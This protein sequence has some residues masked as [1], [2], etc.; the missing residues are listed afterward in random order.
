MS[1][2]A[3]KR[4]RV[5]SRSWLWLQLLS[6]LFLGL[7]SVAYSEGA[8]LSSKS[9]VLIFSNGDRLTGQLERM[10]GGTVFFKTVDAGEIKISWDKIKEMHTTQ[11]F[12]VITIPIHGKPDLSRARVNWGAFDMTKQTLNLHEH[13]GE[14]IIPVKDIAYIVDEKTYRTAVSQKRFLH[15]WIGSFTAGGS[16][17]TS[18]QNVNAYSSSL[19]LIRSVPSAPWLSVSDRTILGF[20]ST[21]GSI[22][23]QNTPTLSTDIYHGNVEQDKYFSTNFY[24][25]VHAIFDHNSTQG[26]NLQ[27]I[28]GA[29]VGYTAFKSPSQL[30]DLSAT[31]DYTDQQFVVE[32]SNQKLVGS[33]FGESYN[34]KTNQF[35]VI[36]AENASITPEWN[37]MNAYLAS[38]NIGLT[39]PLVKT[40]AFSL[41][42]IDSYLNDPPLGFASNSLQINAGLTVMVS[43]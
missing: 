42:V 10:E 26:L 39:L 13:I 9:D 21:Y 16:N 12:A 14:M 22:S 11:N 31:M 29:G 6:L 34:L 15:G 35:P 3:K 41:Q 23:Q 33:T 43:D 37:N 5:F 20:T 18:T 19:S 38:F 25:L 27:Q 2:I 28:Y 7:P 40:L 1:P 8:P 30:F 17:V 4:S 32:G 24:A 36:L